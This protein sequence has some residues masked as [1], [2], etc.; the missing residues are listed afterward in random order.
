M[1]SVVIPVYNEEDGILETIQGLEKALA[2]VDHE[3]IVVDDGS[4]DATVEIVKS[5]KG[6][7]LVHH[8]ENRGYGAS[9]KTGMRKAAGEW[10]LTI[11]ADASYPT[12]AIPGIIGEFEDYDMVVGSRVGEDVNIESYRRPA[13]WILSRLADYLSGTHIPDLNSGLRAFKKQV[14]TDFANLLP[15][16]FSFTTTL[17]L[18]MLCNDHPVKY[19]PINYHQ[20]MGK[21]KIKPFRDGVNFMLLI[22]RTITYFNPLKVFLPAS[23]LLFILSFLVFAYT[24]FIMGMLMDVSVIILFVAAVQTAVIGLLADL[25]VRKRDVR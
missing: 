14:A 4:S 13:K 10:I 22:V 5:I 24:R 17:T 21:S 11:D 19:V 1:I 25:I 9:L 12:D 3:L 23:T 8:P 2:G 16:G 18:A 20:R 7:T 6:V 15:S